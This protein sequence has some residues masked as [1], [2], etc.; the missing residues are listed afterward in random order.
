[1]L[2]KRL[3][4]KIMFGGVVIVA[5]GIATFGF[6][7]FT[8]SL[9]AMQ[10]A[11]Q[12]NIAWSA[13]QLERELTRFQ[14]SM[15]TARAGSSNSSADINQR[16]DVLWS[17]VAIFQRGKVGE[18]L[19]AYDDD[20]VIGRLF[21]ELKRQEVAVVSI[22][23]F[24]FTALAGIS[25]AFYPFG[26]ELH[27]LSRSVVVG[28]EEAAAQIRQQMSHGANFALYASISTVIMVIGALMYFVYEGQQYRK[29][30]DRNKVLADQFKQASVVKSRFLTMMSHELRTPMNGVLGL[31]A[32]ARAVEQD[33]EQQI[34]LNQVDRSANRM[35]DMLTD[36]LDFAALE[37][38]HLILTEKPF[39]SN[40]LLLALPELLGPVAT[41]AE[42]KLHVSAA[43][44]LPV[45]LCGDPKRLRRSYALMVT[46]FLETA[47]ARDIALTLS[48]EGGQL[49]ARII[50]DYVGGGW[51]PD[52]IF[53][54]RAESLESFAAEALGPSVARVLIEKMSGE[55]A[56]STT[57]DDKILLS[58]SVPV[59]ALE[60][61][62]LKVRLQ[63]QSAPMEMI[64][65]SSLADIPIEYIA[66][67]S[68]TKA[69]IIIVETGASDE[70]EKLKTLRANSPDALV[71]GIG[72]SQNP[73]LFD[74]VADVPLE[75][76]QLR[77]R[78]SEA[79]G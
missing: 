49:I 52:L 51:S 69:E 78:L 55:I 28:E 4:S 75:A 79:L 37:N 71:F 63:T 19:R 58:I 12:E 20:N 22:S 74:F 11:R 73:A 29:L 36:I 9:D 44:D 47:G 48:Y 41:Q 76:S 18:R 25:N 39:F 70:V 24:D 2:K 17:R 5:V 66:P 42:A 14:D 1:M 72:R 53:G 60:A 61:R 46:Y 16:F 13:S 30:A 67:N 56:L 33:E 43:D 65:K 38:A 35:L 15:G 59:A 62:K 8:A 54:E 26:D 3:I 27:E 77:N 32:L 23:S 40:E 64:C 7:T 50:V 45:M 57:E 6:L 31:L 21:E 34:R 10:R 68:S